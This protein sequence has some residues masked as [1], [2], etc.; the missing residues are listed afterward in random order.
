MPYARASSHISNHTLNSITSHTPNSSSNHMLGNIIRS[1]MSQVFHQLQPH[2]HQ[3]DQPDRK[4][5]STS[6]S[7]VR[8]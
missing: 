5:V 2:P 6:G 1:G 8:R 7:P 4:T 3:T